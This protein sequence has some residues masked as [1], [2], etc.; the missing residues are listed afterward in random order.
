MANKLDNIYRKLSRTNPKLRNEF[1]ISMI[2]RAYIAPINRTLKKAKVFKLT[3]PYF[4]V[5]KTHGN[6][7]KPI[8]A[9]RKKY[10]REYHKRRNKKETWTDNELLG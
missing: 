4:G 3:I 5:I 6:K 1:A 2:L 7:K 9:A 8:S 10:Q